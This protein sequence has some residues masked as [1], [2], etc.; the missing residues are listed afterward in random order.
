MIW[1]GKNNLSR[2]GPARLEKMRSLC[3]VQFLSLRVWQSSLGETTAIKAE[4]GAS[5]CP[6]SVCKAKPN[7]GRDSHDCPSCSLC[8][9][10]FDCTYCRWCVVSNGDGGSH[11]G[12]DRLASSFSNV[13]QVAISQERTETCCY[14]KSIARFSHLHLHYGV[15]SVLP[16]S[17]PTPDN[18]IGR[19][20][21]DYPSNVGSSQLAI[22]SIALNR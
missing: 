6:L 12:S 19:K 3:K 20:S 9:Q 10:G 17:R 16:R 8:Y 14:R 7:R 15:I 5:F 18:F 4:I 11:G 13:E 1:E 2:H 21:R 22:H